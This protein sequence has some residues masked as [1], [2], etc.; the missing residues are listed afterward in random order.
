MVKPWFHWEADEVL[1]M[2]ESTRSGLSGAEA[3]RR[4]R[5][6]GPNILAEEDRSRIGPILLRQF[7][8]VMILILFAAAA[9]AAWM[10][11]RTDAVMILACKAF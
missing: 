6:H 5:R 3:E 10:G 8:D 9:I 1:R 4:F 11:D 7:T 2:L